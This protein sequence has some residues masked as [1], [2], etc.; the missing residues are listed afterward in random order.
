MESS[1]SRRSPDLYARIAA[2]AAAHLA[3]GAQLLIGLSG[4][5]DSTVLLHALAAARD[6]HR[7]RL[8]CAHVHH[9]LSPNADAWADHCAVQ[10][11]ALG[12]PFS[13]HRVQ[14][15]TASPDGL[16]CAARDARYRAL[17][18]Q[19]QALGADALLTAHH[20]DDQAETLLHNMV[21]GAGLL[22]LAGMPVWRP[23]T[24]SR[25]AQLRPLLGLSRVSLE[26][27]AR[28]HGLV[29]M[30]DESNADIRYARN[31]LRRE[32]MPRLAARWPRTAE[33]MSGVA[34]RLAEAQTLLDGLADADAAALSM[35]TEWGIAWS[36]DGLRALDDARSR[37]LLRRLLRV[38][39][40]RTA[41][42]E[43]WLDE[44]LRQIRAWQP[45]AECPVTHAGVAGFC[46]R[47]LL[48]L[49]PDQPPPAAVVWQGET[50]IAW[51]PGCLRFDAVIGRGF[52]PSAL[53]TG[54]LTIRARQPKDRVCRGPGR[55]R[56]GVK[57]IAQECGLPPWLRDR[58][59]ILAVGR[60]ALWMPGCEPAPPWQA[61]PGEPGWL[62]VWTP[63]VAQ[64]TP[65]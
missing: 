23:P 9:G 28:A 3:D 59:P 48:W 41:P 34:R 2:S 1:R 64:S 20:A 18:A 47:G 39:G 15:D 55:P 31:Y 44:W 22:G 36:I 32:V 46:H 58:A 10:A 56:A 19:A 43:A 54:S 40:A 27:C 35:A 42:T 16:E 21:R 57:Q 50:D 4:G 12:I 6:V 5:L 62:P 24:P 30:E 60:E 7:W 13:L 26:M 8:A 11:A 38:H 33:T 29:W 25:P 52:A 14:V 37:N 61:A 65:G 53:P 17:N 45:G 51:G 63:V 49:M